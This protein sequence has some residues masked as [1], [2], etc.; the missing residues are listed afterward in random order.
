MSPTDPAI[1]QNA[2]HML[3]IFISQSSKTKTKIL[4]KCKMAVSQIPLKK[5]TKN[6]AMTSQLMKTKIAKTHDISKKQKNKTNK[7]HHDNMKNDIF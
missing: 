3:S 1:S 7:K 2:D 6:K 5:Q 4:Q